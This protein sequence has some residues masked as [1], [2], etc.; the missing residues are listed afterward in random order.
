MKTY[1]PSQVSIVIGGHTLSGFADGT[2]VTVVRDE[3]SWSLAI[4]TDGEGARAKSNNKSG[5]ITVTLLQ[6]SDSNRIL[7]DF[8]LADELSNSGVFPLLVKDASGNSLYTAETAWV[9][10]PADSEFAREVGN[11]EWTIRTD[12]LQV[13]VGGN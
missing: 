8:A 3:D 9:Q 4:G 6:T 5:T 11:R 10:K 1:D 13:Y 12:N 7:S 2:F